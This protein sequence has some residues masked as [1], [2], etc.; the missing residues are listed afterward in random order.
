MQCLLCGKHHTTQY[1]G[2]K[3]YPKKVINQNFKIKNKSHQSMLDSIRESFGEVN[4]KPEK[5]CVW[6]GGSREE[7]SDIQQAQRKDLESLCSG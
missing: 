5:F 3:K 2:N 4:F 7:R 6:T 1:I